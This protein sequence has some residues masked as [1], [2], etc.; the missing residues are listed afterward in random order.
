V[1]DPTIPNAHG[2]YAYDGE[3]I[4]SEKRYL[5]KDGILNTLLYDLEMAARYNVPT[6]GAARAFLPL[7]QPRIGLSNIYISPKDASLEE[8][9]AD[10]NNGLYLIGSAGGYT[11]NNGSFAI[12]AQQGIIIK[13][14]ELVE[15]ESYHFPEITGWN[16]EFLNNVQLVGKDF[17]MGNG[18]FCDKQGSTIPIEVGGPTMS[19]KQL[20]IGSD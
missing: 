18:S 13:N 9:F 4:K 17:K 20:Y 2:S 6:N 14:G 19:I 15:E 1:D 3:G 5:I 16:H 7:E 12:Q 10:C 11:F 8:L